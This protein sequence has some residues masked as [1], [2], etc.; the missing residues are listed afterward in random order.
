MSTKSAFITIG[1]KE[2]NEE[3]RINEGDILKLVT[4]ENVIFTSMRRTKFEAKLNGRALLVPVWRNKHTMTPFVTEKLGTDLSV[5]KVKKKTPISSFKVGDIF[6]L[7]GSKE[8]FM[9]NG[10]RVKRGGKKVVIGVDLASKTT[11]DIAEG[12]TFTKISIPL[13]KKELL[14]S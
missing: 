1:T 10:T 4:G 12:M 6:S 8:T 5:I 14:K 7:D 2:V 11:F 3:I 13:F 9:F